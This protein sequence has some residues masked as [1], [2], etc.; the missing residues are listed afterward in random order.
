MPGSAGTIFRVARYAIHD[1]PGIRTTVF[2]K[3][4]PLRCAWCHS[5]ESQKRPPQ[6]LV[7]PERNEREICGRE[8]TIDEV[9]AL[10]ERDRT[11]FDESGGGVTFSG[12]EP[13]AQP[14]FL[15]SLIDACRAREIHTAVETSGYATPDVLGHIRPDLFLFDLKIMD[16]TRHRSATGVS[17][18]R[19]LANA[20]ALAASETPVRFRF[21][22]I[23]GVND[24]EGNRREVAAF[25]KSIGAAAIDILPYHRAGIAK[26]ARL[27]IPYA[28]PDTVEPAPADVERVR[29]DFARYGVAAQIGG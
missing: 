11:F 14:L 19:I 8:A 27:G 10:V 3:G 18:K 29:D 21:P 4:C 13:L 5:P 23:P 15:A 16:E 9:L 22:L 7:H 2:L 26:Y 12:G 28:L 1:G 25:V 6:P 17:N 20:R 24:E